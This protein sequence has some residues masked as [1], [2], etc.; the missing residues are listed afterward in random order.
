VSFQTLFD[1]C[2]TVTTRSGIV[3]RVFNGTSR[4]FFLGLRD[5]GTDLGRMFWVDSR[6]I[7]FEVKRHWGRVNSTEQR[8]SLY[9]LCSSARRGESDVRDHTYANPRSRNLRNF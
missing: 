8:R 7:D 5:W 3:I 2:P 6:G 4:T 9:H 1:Q